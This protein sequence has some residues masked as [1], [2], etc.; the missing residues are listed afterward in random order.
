MSKTRKAPKKPTPSQVELLEARA[1][2]RAESRVIA[3][4]LAD[5]A[6]AMSPAEREKHLAD[7][8]LMLSRHAP[9]AEAVKSELLALLF[10]GV[11]EF[12]KRYYPDA[13]SAH[14]SIKHGIDG[15]MDCWL[16]VAFPA[17]AKAESV[18]V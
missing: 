18:P 15:G 5:R 7:L 3:R 13:E 14:I 17:K 6:T 16:P 12:C 4:K 11:V 9:T 8:D 2:A 1:I 10:A